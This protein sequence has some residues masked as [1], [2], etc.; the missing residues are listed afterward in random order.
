V[1]YRV[2]FL[3]GL[4]VTCSAQSVILTPKKSVVRGSLPLLVKEVF[5][6]AAEKNEDQKSLT[7]LGNMSLAIKNSKQWLMATALLPNIK[8]TFPLLNIKTHGK[9]WFELCKAYPKNLLL[10]QVKNLVEHNLNK[11]QIKINSIELLSNKSSLCFPQ[12]EKIK[13]ITLQKAPLLTQQVLSKIQ[14]THGSIVSLAW[15]LTFQVKGMVTLTLINANEIIS[16]KSWKIAWITVNHINL[17]Q[18]QQ[19]TSADLLSRRRIYPDTLLTKVNSKHLP[20]I[21]KGQIVHLIMQQ[22]G[23]Y[24]ETQAKALSSGNLGQIVTVLAENATQTIKAKVN[25]KGEVSAFF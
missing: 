3:L 22:P 5:T 23:F 8:E 16:P 12:G 9:L 15:K 20:L 25:K 1:L 4:F 14:L 24:I 10:K 2:L 7:K 21:K 18:L 11:Q 17:A 6:I 19:T 13:R